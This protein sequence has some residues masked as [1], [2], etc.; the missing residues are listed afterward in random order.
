MAQYSLTVIIQVSRGFEKMLLEPFFQDELFTVAAKQKVLASDHYFCLKKKVEVRAFQNYFLISDLLDIW[1]TLF[2]FFYFF[3]VFKQVPIFSVILVGCCMS[4]KCFVVYK[5]F[6]LTL[7]WCEGELIITEI[8]V[9]LNQ[10][11][12]TLQ[13]PHCWDASNTYKKS[14]NLANPIWFWQ[15]RMQV[16]IIQKYW[17]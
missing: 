17:I 16:V 15:E 1:V 4:Q 11:F 5:T 3:N 14:A 9:L 6:H 8:L 13:Q 12:A 7:F 2:I 10:N